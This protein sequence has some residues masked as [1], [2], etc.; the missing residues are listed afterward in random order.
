MPQQRLVTIELHD[1]LNPQTESCLRDFFD[2]GWSVVSTNTT[3]AA[4]SIGNRRVV[5]WV[6]VLL[7]R[8]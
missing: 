6:V 5:S 1:N 2:R 7:E 3:G 8:S 4:Y